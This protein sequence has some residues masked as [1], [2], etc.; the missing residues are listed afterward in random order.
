MR[1]NENEMKKKV[2]HNDNIMKKWNII[3]NTMSK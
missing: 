3:E 1:R 2:I